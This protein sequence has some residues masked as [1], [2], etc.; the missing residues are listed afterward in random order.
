MKLRGC[1]ACCILLCQGVRAVEIRPIELRIVDAVSGEPISHALVYYQLRAARNRNALG[2]PFDP[3]QYRGIETRRYETDV[4]GVLTIPRRNIDL[5]RFEVPFEE[6]IFVNVDLEGSSE[7]GTA[8][9]KAQAF[10]TQ[11]QKPL[12]SW[13]EKYE[14]GLVQTASFTFGDDEQSGCITNRGVRLSVIA[15]SNSLKQT[16][17]AVVVPLDR[18]SEA[19]KGTKP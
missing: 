10:F 2:M 9:E 11:W 18:K 12:R 14:G 13:D 1:L 15:R 5:R 7:K 4:N 19:E 17:D 8:E 6:W 3:V 16:S